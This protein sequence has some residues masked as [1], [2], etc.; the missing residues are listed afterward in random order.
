MAPLI[1]I[2]IRLLFKGHS[3]QLEFT[4]NRDVRPGAILKLTYNP[5]DLYSW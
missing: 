4:Y 1:I 5:F 3:W 2:A